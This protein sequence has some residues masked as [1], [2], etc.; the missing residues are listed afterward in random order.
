MA[1]A[2]AKAME[3]VE[4]QITD[5][6]VDFLGYKTLKDLLGSL[7]RSSFGAHDTRDMATGVEA[8]GASKIYEFGDSMNL[9]VNTTLFSA[10]QPRG[11]EAADQP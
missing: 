8:S 11:V 4:V 6:S 10:L 7:G 2:A 1:G 9:D 3:Q 5:K